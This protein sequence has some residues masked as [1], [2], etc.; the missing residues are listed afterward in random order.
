[1]RFIRSLK[2]FFFEKNLRLGKLLQYFVLLWIFFV[3]WLYWVRL[4]IPGFTKL[5][6]WIRFINTEAAHVLA[7][8]FAA[9]YLQ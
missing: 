5:D 6:E 7:K 3:L 4:G 9:S 1:M 8:Y 2:N